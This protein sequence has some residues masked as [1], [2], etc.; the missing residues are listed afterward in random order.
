MQVWEVP[1][2]P[3][4]WG[5]KLGNTGLWKTFLLQMLCPPSSPCPPSLPNPA[6]LLSSAL[7][8]VPRAT[9]SS[10]QCR[11]HMGLAAPESPETGLGEGGCVMIFF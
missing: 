5:V 11:S 7:G 2:K 10:N 4:W 1:A 8:T 6:G 3:C 9:G